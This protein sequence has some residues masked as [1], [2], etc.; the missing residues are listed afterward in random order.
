MLKND[1]LSLAR[2]FEGSPPLFTVGEVV[3]LEDFFAYGISNNTT[4]V[5]KSIAI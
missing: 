3:E 5:S 2:T 4:Y 1:F